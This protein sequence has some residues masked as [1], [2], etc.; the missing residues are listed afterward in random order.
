[1]WQPQNACAVVIDQFEEL[2][3]FRRAG[4]SARSLQNCASR[5]EAS[6]F[7]AML[8]AAARMVEQRLRVMITMRSDFV[9]DCEVFLGLPQAVSQSQFLVPRLTRSQMEAAITGPSQIR[10]AGFEPYDF[11]PGLVNTLINEAGDR[12]DQLPLL[13]HVLMRTWKESDRKRLTEADY[14]QAGRI[15]KALSNDADAAWQQLD[16][17]G[18]RLARQMFLLLCDVSLEGQITRRRPLAQEVM[19]V[20]QADCAQIERVVR[21]FQAEDRN[22]L[23]PPSP[24][25]IWLPDLDRPGSQ[26]GSAVSALA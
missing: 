12:P 20:A 13:Q 1:M 9:G 21:V 22:F 5:D 11:Q 19:D 14:T 17:D 3:G 16:A 23:L 26:I 7:V 6:A 4:D 18:Q 2:F 24:Q 25:P 8:L 10:Q 15:E